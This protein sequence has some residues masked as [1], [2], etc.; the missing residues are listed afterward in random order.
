MPGPQTYLP[1]PSPSPVSASL[2][3]LGT[4]RFV[5][6]RK[7]RLRD[8]AGQTS[9]SRQ[10]DREQD[11]RTTLLNPQTPTT[12][13]RPPRRGPHLVEA[14]DGLKGGHGACEGRRVLALLLL[15]LI[16]GLLVRVVLQHL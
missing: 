2:A 12:N 4:G 11:Q 13:Y 7:A 1:L 5:L 6:V 14:V 15:V 8:M 3:L 10:I 9:D 16:G